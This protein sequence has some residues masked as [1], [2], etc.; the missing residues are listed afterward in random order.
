LELAKHGDDVTPVLWTALRAEEPKAAPEIEFFSTPVD[1][2]NSVRWG[3][4]AFVSMA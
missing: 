2:E 3:R 1:R 4:I